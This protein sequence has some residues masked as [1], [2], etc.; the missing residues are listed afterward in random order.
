MLGHELAHVRRADWLVQMAAEMVR[1]LYWF[2][3]LLWNACKRLR[4][5]SERACDD[6]VLNLGVDGSAYATQ[7]VDLART[8][9]RRRRSMFPPLPAP[10]IARP[11]SL[12]KRIRAMLSID[13]NRRPITHA[14]MIE[15]S[16]TIS[17]GAARRAAASARAR[18]VV[19]SQTESDPCSQSPVGGC[20]QP[21]TKVRD[22]RPAYP[23]QH[24]DAKVEGQ[25]RVEARIGTDGF[26][27][28]LRVLAP[29]DPAFAEATL[30]AL[31]G[32]QF[33]ATRLDG[34][35]VEVGI[36][37]TANFRVQ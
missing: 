14:G 18:E 35:P 30:A 31:Q 28:D 1:S 19:A 37:V 12:E 36:G 9:T 27:K 23:S 21:P 26:L 4:E 6:A 24:R 13:L 17:D 33:T 25:V 22:L 5:E 16:I 7:L 2:N 29:A 10:A 11:S 3:P 8:F 15:Q 20:I 32:W 34:V